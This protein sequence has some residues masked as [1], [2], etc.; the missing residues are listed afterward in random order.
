ML[1]KSVCAA[2]LVLSA[3]ALNQLGPSTQEIRSIAERAYTFAYPIVLMEYTR[4]SAGEGDSLGGV[5]QP[6]RFTHAEAFPDASFRTVVRPNAD[7]LY[8]SAWLDLSKEPDILHVPDTHG[9]YYLMQFMDAW[10]ETFSIPGKRTTGTAE[11]WFAIAGPGWKGKLP[12]RAR[13]ID[14][15][16]NMVWLIGRTQ[17]NGPS[18]YETVHAIQRGYVLMPL[19]LYPDGPPRPVARLRRS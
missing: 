8:S 5:A 10:T 15:P 18:D 16:T 4:R 12:D 13:R 3:W 1:R 19:S 9:R 2:V 17:T 7:T 14:A 11:G 6:N